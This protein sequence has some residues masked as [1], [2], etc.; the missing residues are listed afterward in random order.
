M[1]QQNF[2]FHV[3]SND[4]GLQTFGDESENWIAEFKYCNTL[5]AQAWGMKLQFGEQLWT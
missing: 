5:C 2:M 4:G 1:C 3:G